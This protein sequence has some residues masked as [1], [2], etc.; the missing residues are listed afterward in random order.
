MTPRTSMRKRRGFTII[1]T[2]VALIVL[3]AMLAVSVP[4]FVG[5]LDDAANKQCRAQMQSISNQEEQYR[6]KSATH[7]Y[8]TDLTTLPGASRVI[9]VC[10]S[11][12]TYIAIIADGSQHTQ[13]L[14]AIPVAN[15]IINCSKHGLFAPGVDNR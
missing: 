15:L 3:A 12:G 2:L 11:G 5:A 7:T 8:T 6:L 1:E 4:I 14:V 10:P 13:N 9:P